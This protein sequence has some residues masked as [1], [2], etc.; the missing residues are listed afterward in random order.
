MKTEKMKIRSHRFICYDTKNGYTYEITFNKSL[1]HTCRMDAMCKGL[2]RFD[3][4]SS[5][6]FIIH[7]VISCPLI[8]TKTKWATK[9]YYYTNSKF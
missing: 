8:L 2:D 6:W 4:L 5:F 3:R 9:L 1:E 7:S